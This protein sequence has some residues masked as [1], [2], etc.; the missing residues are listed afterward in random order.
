[1]DSYENQSFS[2]NIK[3][4]C[5]LDLYIKDHINEITRKNKTRNLCKK[6]HKSIAYIRRNSLA[7]EYIYITRSCENMSMNRKTTAYSNN[8]NWNPWF[9]SQRGTSIYTISVYKK[10]HTMK[11]LVRTTKLVRSSRK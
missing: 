11:S 4:T 10:S 3:G 6:Q 5:K 8:S 9:I 7:E 1:M 2:G